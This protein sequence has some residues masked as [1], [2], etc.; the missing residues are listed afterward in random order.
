MIEV[1]R[2]ECEPQESM[3]TKIVSLVAVWPGT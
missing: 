2:I 3:E 1:K